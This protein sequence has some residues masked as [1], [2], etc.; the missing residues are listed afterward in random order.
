MWWRQ[1][2]E[3]IKVILGNVIVWRQPGVYETLLQTKSSVL[4]K[5]ELDNPAPSK[6]RGRTEISAGYPDSAAH[7]SCPGSL[8]T[9]QVQ[10]V[11]GIVKSA[12]NLVC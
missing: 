3:K 12:L 8:K 10:A 5:Q 1:K 9:L 6:C 4:K 2:D 11:P 7:Q